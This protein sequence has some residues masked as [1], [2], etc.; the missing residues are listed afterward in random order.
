MYTVQVYCNTS[1]GLLVTLPTPS[2]FHHLT[3]PPTLIK[4]ALKMP[5]LPDILLANKV[6]EENKS[7]SLMTL[8]SLLETK[9]IGDVCSGRQPATQAFLGAEG[10]QCWIL[11]GGR[12][13][14]LGTIYFSS[15]S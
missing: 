3:P 4:I 13:Q 11:K 9:E 14:A 8:V 15:V 2:S 5:D 6:N 1:P 7:K 10:G 12:R